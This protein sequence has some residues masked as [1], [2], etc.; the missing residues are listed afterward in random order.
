MLSHWIIIA[1]HLRVE[2]LGA[3]HPDAANTDLTNLFV[4]QLKT[5]QEMQS[6]QKPRFVILQ[7]EEQ[8]G[9]P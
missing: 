7:V 5:S 2:D 4:L 3:G 1:I 8:S 6:R 9:G